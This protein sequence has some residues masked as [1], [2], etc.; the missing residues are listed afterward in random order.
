MS[1]LAE[2]CSLFAKIGSGM[3]HPSQ[4]HI[5]QFWSYFIFSSLLGSCSNIR[6]IMMIMVAKID[7]LPP[8]MMVVNKLVQPLAPHDD[9]SEQQ[10]GEGFVRPPRSW[11]N[12]ARRT[13]VPLL[14]TPP[15]VW[16]DLCTFAV[17][18]VPEHC[19]IFHF[20]F[21]R[22]SVRHRRGISTF[23]DNLWFRPWNP[24]LNAYH[25]GWSSWPTWPPRQ[26]STTQCSPVH[27]ITAQHSPHRSRKCKKRKK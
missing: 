2:Y 10:Q 8:M 16:D 24:Y 6:V 26:P 9:G 7:L 3:G 22:T 21:V 4:K 1:L 14:W 15:W 13:K 12:P 11:S 23:L 5:L 27:S 17:S 19:T 18:G 20:P 25:L